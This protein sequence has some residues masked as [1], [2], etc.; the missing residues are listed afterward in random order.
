MVAAQVGIG[1]L[2]WVVAGLVLWVIL[3]DGHALGFGPFLSAF[4]LAQSAG[5]ISHVPGGLGVFEAVFLSFLPH[6]PEH[7][8]VLASL[9]AFRVIY[10]LVP[11]FTAA[12]ALGAREVFSHRR[13]V[14]EPAL[15]A[16]QAASQLVPAASAGLAFVLGGV[17]VLSG[18]IPVP[19]GRLEA[20][21]ALLPLPIVELSHFA[22]SVVG[23]GLLVLARGLQRRLDGAYH[24]TLSFLLVGVV[25]SLTRGLHVVAALS[26]LVGAGVVFAS[27]RQFYRRASLLDEPF[28]PSWVLAICAVLATAVWLGL[29]AY[30]HV[31]YTS[32][33]W[34]RFALREDAPRF[35][36][37]SVGAAMGL[38]VF[39]TARLLRPAPPDAEPADEET[40]R[41]IAP[42]VD[43]SPT[44]DA[45]LV[46][47][48][49]KEVLLSESGR[50]FLMYAVSGSS[51]VVMGDPVG[52]PCEFEGLAWRL[53]E[54]ADRAGDQVVFYEVGP[55][56]LPLYI[57]LGLVFFKL[58]EEGRV[59]LADF[60]LEGKARA[61]LRQA[62]RRL[63][64]EGGAFEVVPRDQLAPL[65]PRLREISDEWLAA[66]SVREKG[67][68]LGRFDEDYLRR[69]PCGV[70]SVNGLPVA[71]GTLWTSE[72]RHEL[73]ID[74]MR[75]SDQA[76]KGVMDALFANLLLWG[77]S[78]GYAWFSLGMAPFSGMETHRLAP[79]WQKMGAA[80]Y[81]YG[82]HFY[83][84]QG[85]RDYKEKFEP[86]WEPR[87][88]AAP[89]GIGVAGILTD[90]TSLISGGLRG[91]VTR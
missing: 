1:V 66:R 76:P 41:K 53:M 24:L 46:F 47:L 45:N 79:A 57:D 89:P 86:V 64:R 25:L 7:Q 29:F 21:D 72:S 37:A 61:D 84:F 34:W 67:F 44:S 9:L 28:T 87:Y 65:L 83:N 5:V 55:T 11:L 36:R 85:L 22:G 75:Y 81:R 35:L 20:L 91:V 26:F 27:R 62:A 38:A 8:R 68:S 40:L 43:A 71:F 88:L 30:Q 16:A 13:E 78:Q 31:E 6:G 73:S 10:Y 80:L 56:W 23:V 48:K 59:P 14:G 15:R 69:F 74:L 50:S 42:L 77:Q 52:D 4:L 39:V 70:I 19:A 60:S 54:R 2:D 32:D 33:L 58:G 18:S 82:E 3:P 51:W 17:L 12:V 63:E 49:D 90:V